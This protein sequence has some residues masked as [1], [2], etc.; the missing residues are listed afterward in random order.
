MHIQ[1]APNCPHCPAPPLIM[2]DCQ[3]C[4][5]YSSDT[6][7]RTI[8]AVHVALSHITNSLLFR[9]QRPS[10]DCTATDRP[11]CRYNVVASHS[12]WNYCAWV[13][14]I[15]C[16]RYTVPLAMC[17]PSYTGTCVCVRVRIRCVARPVRFWRSWRFV[18][19][20]Q[21]TVIALQLPRVYLIYLAFLR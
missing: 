4:I 17:R 8:H 11:I 5:Q 16:G 9:P 7:Y 14:Q 20:C 15:L 3:Q 18:W 10:C 6:F 1:T 13:I 2:G 19:P 21:V 12:C